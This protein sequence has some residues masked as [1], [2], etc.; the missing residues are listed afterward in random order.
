MGGGREGWREELTQTEQPQA[1][2]RKHARLS[3][4]RVLPAACTKCKNGERICV[5]M[6][7]CVRVSLVCRGRGVYVCECV[8]VCAGARVYGT[9]HV[10]SRNRDKRAN[11][12][13]GA[14]RARTWRKCV[15]VCT[16]PEKLDMRVHW[17]GGEVVCRKWG[18]FFGGRG[19]GRGVAARARH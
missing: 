1:C 13:S 5:R 14:G 15:C 19:G 8:C 9:L 10:S 18:S 3:G 17:E 12:G 16:E 7:V 4:G 11:K 2:T 6:C